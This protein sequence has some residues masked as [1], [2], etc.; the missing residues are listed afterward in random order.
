[1]SSY[2]AA[3]AAAI[4][5]FERTF[6]RG[7][8]EL[9]GGNVSKAARES[10][11]DRVYFHKMLTKHGVRTKRVSPPSA[12]AFDVGSLVL[13]SVPVYAIETSLPPSSHACRLTKPRERGK[14]LRK[15]D[16]QTYIVHFSA[17]CVAPVHV[18]SMEVES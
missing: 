11:L 16:H 12:P 17:G 5:E 10:G 14:V 1:M 4:A 15:V 18:S 2:K 6:A 9:A 7:A 13:V 3:R 8:L